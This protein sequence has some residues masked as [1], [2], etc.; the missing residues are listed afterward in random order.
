MARVRG[1]TTPSRDRI[2]GVHIAAHPA[3][4]AGSGGL[5]W[6]SGR[7]GYLILRPFDLARVSEMSEIAV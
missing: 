5:I 3:E 4:K 2:A 1:Q 6:K 7:V